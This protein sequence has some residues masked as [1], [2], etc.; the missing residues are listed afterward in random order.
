MYTHG[1]GV[2]ADEKRAKHYAA[3]HAKAVENV[4]LVDTLARMF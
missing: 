4:E 2:D 3:K 1:L